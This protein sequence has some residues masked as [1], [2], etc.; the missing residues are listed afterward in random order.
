M[1]HGSLRMLGPSAV[2]VA[3]LVVASCGQAAPVPSGQPGATQAGVAPAPSGVVAPSLTPN[4]QATAV[5]AAQAEVDDVHQLDKEAGIAALIGPGGPTVLANLD[6][7]KVQHGEKTL[8]E[9][10]AKLRV[11]LS[12]MRPG[13]ADVGMPPVSDSRAS[14][15]WTGSLLGEVST[16]A[17]MVMAF[18]PAA[19]DNL[20]GSDQS[21]T[22]TPIDRTETYTPQPHDGT[23]ESVTITTKVTVSVGG[24]KVS[25][26]L[27]I[28]SVDTLTDQASGKQV[29]QLQGTAHGHIDVNACP[30]GNGVAPGSYQLTLHEELNRAG[31][32]GAGSNK[33]VKA[34]F[35]LIDGDDAHLVRIED[36]LQVDKHANGPGTSGGD[37]A[38]PFDWSVSATI[39]ESIAPSGAV[40]LNGGTW[41]SDGNATQPQIDGT[42]NGRRSAES[43]LQQIAK[44]TE[45]FWRSG[46]C[47]DL[48]PSEESRK[49]DPNQAV[50]VTVD[51]VGHFDGQ[52]I[53]GP[54]KAAFSG[55]SS[56]KP[57]AAKPPA[58][59]F[60]FT[61]GSKTGDVGTIDLSQTSKRGIGKKQVVFT[62]GGSAVAFAG[63][64]QTP[65]GSPKIF[66][67]VGAV[68][69]TSDLSG[70]WAVIS[71]GNPDFKL[72]LGNLIA[73][74][75]APATRK[76]VELVKAGQPFTLYGES[77]LQGVLNPS[78]GPPQTVTLHATLPGGGG[79]SYSRTF[80]LAPVD[81][82]QM[83]DACPT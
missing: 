56:L 37:P 13:L 79:Y 76:Y 31:Q 34:P 80:D 82:P 5:D 36:E 22:E 69:C 32:P 1:R 39:P 12:A 19:I 54:I 75:N 63:S 40:T 47:I 52:P 7:A 2:A 24:G 83:P 59:P 8:P 23:K 81:P 33:D 70:P 44:E 78:S 38:G 10:A 66:A 14:T 60:D 6:A 68:S 64:Y 30:D 25:M 42:V 46:K 41:K 50:H 29:A 51:A 49:V 28:T 15:D 16:T 53:D 74:M 18:L 9:I 26:D 48:K 61:A 3:I 72:T 58:A 55:T 62:V 27:D 73:Q 35:R 71:F 77:Q 57:D 17:T 4:D 67:P 20:A 21:G 11:P 43:Y 45:K 65:Y